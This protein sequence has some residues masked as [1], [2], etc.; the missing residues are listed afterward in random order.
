[1][2][3]RTNANKYTQNNNQYKC[4]S[5]ELECNSPSYTM[6]YELRLGHNNYHHFNLN[7]TK[8]QNLHKI[9][10]VQFKIETQGNKW[11]IWRFKKGEGKGLNRRTPEHL[12]ISDV[13][14]LIVT[15]YFDE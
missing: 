3:T 5:R 12:A 7:K 10:I 1:M 11:Y 8:N 4:H 13:S 15:H 14:I 2:Q 9:P 6:W